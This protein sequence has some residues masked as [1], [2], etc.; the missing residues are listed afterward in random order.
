MLTTNPR[1]TAAEAVPAALQL[2]TEAMRR[3]HFLR[4]RQGLNDTQIAGVLGCTR[5]WA[6]KLR[7]EYRRRADQV[8]DLCAAMGD[9][10]VLPALLN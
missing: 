6:C 5:E 1:S 2:P 10:S 3:A 7:G 9:G 4:A 8:R